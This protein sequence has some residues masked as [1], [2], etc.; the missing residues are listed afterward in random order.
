MK[1]LII[2]PMKA[3]Y[4]KEIESTLDSLREI[5]EGGIQTT[6][7]FDDMVCIVCNDEAKNLGLDP[8]RA[9]YDEK[10]RIYDVIAGTFLIVG[11]NED[12]FCSLTKEQT[13]KYKDM[14]LRPEVFARLGDRILVLPA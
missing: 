5:V 4:T 11:I 8:N 1:V 9:L 3:P 13:R 12:D 10:G 2:E 7:P 6:Y 14:F